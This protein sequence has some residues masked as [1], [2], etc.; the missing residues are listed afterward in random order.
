MYLQNRFS[1]M[2]NSSKGTHFHVAEQEVR[3]TEGQAAQGKQVED[4]PDPE[5]MHPNRWKD[6]A[7]KI[8][9]L[10]FHIETRLKLSN[11]LCA[12]YVPDLGRNLGRNLCNDCHGMPQ[13]VRWE[14]RYA[15]KRVMCALLHLRL[16]EKRSWL[17][18]RESPS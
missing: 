2:R 10:R 15:N 9:R 14:L 17:P 8:N 3:P 18:V 11:L 16:Q 5:I 13:I 6:A 4:L 7:L 12:V 1:G